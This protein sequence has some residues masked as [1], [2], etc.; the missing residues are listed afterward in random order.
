MLEAEKLRRD[1]QAFAEEMR[2]SSRQV[3]VLC[4][5]VQALSS[6]V[7]KFNHRVQVLRQ[8]STHLNSPPAASH[9]N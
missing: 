1:L 9:Q 5:D 7:D 2:R 6:E 3:D 4:N 8:K